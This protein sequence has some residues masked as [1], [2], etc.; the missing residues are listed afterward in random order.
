MQLMPVVGCDSMVQ[1]KLHNLYQGCNGLRS[2]M[3]L[4]PVVEEEG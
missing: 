1:L 4:I 3:Q 2:Q